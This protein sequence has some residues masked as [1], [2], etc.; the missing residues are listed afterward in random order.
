MYARPQVEGLQ[1]VCQVPCLS[2]QHSDMSPCTCR[3]AP[4]QACSLAHAGAR[5]PVCAARLFARPQDPGTPSSVTATSEETSHSEV[6]D[7]K[8][9]T[10]RII[11][12]DVCLCPVCLLA[13][14]LREVVVT[15][16]HERALFS[17]T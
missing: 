3:P 14:S 13:V 12:H 17:C 7:H 2:T 8:G 10:E 6:H 16:D 1:H 15:V 5:R 9:S 11:H 4:N